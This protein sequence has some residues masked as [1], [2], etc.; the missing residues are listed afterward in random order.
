[1]KLWRKST[2]RHYWFNKYWLTC[3]RL[4]FFSIP[5]WQYHYRLCWVRFMLISGRLKSLKILELNNLERLL[6]YFSRDYTNAF[7]SFLEINKTVPAFKNIQY[8]E[9]IKIDP[10]YMSIFD[11]FYKIKVTEMTNLISEEIGS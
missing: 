1:M 6:K 3:S 4:I 7:L 9:I 10:A 2:D 11:R 5:S 8:N